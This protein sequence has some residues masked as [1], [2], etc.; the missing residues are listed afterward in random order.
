M[1]EPT[2]IEIQKQ[3]LEYLRRHPRIGLAARNSQIKS[4]HYLG[5]LGKGSS[6]IV[7]TLRGSGRA[8][9][10]E[11][12]GPKG[13][14]SDDQLFWLEDRRREGC[15]VG[16]ARSVADVA[17]ALGLLASPAASLRRPV[18]LVPS[19]SQVRINSEKVR[20]RSS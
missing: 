3:I 9:F 17:S 14:A 11:V 13:K 4:G 12:K 2:E 8:V 15:V 5:G 20:K 19:G 7:A 6:D 1:G 18:Q 10:I 16:V